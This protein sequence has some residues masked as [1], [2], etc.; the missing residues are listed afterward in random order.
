MRKSLALAVPNGG[1]AK[2]VAAPLADCALCSLGH[3][4]ESRPSEK[5]G[6]SS[7]DIRR[8]RMPFGSEACQ[9][10]MHGQST[11]TP[12]NLPPARCPKKNG[13]D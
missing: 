4:R 9:A 6:V 3:S 12:I 8:A 10:T 1:P 7:S 11:R 2:S 5:R 13:R